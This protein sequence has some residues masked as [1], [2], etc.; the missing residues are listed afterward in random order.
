MYSIKKIDTTPIKFKDLKI[1]S[2]FC[3]EGKLFIKVKEVYDYEIG[4]ANC[5]N[6]YTG[7]FGNISN[8]NYIVLEKYIIEKN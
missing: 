3:M 8:G 4:T 5:V 7:E 1:N 6:I 2:I